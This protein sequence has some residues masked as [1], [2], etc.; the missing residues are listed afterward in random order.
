MIKLKV[1]V[2]LLS[3]C[4]VGAVS[5]DSTTSA[6]S[7]PALGIPVGVQNGACVDQYGNGYT[8]GS[9]V[10]AWDGRLLSCQG[11]LW[12][13]AQPSELPAGTLCG[14]R[15]GTGSVPCG[16]TYPGYG[17]PAGY[18]SMAWAEGNKGGLQYIYYC[19]K[20]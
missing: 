1:L 14:V 11:S 10:F 9:T 12:K 5:A 20:G 16:G 8:T 7:A 3:A 6:G 15:S 13:L 2:A 17:C 4:W 19:V 18:Y